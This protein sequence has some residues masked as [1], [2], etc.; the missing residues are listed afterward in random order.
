MLNL[1]KISTIYVKICL[2][3]KMATSKDYKNFIL[4]KLSKLN[5]CYKSMMGEFLLYVNGVYFGGIFDDRLLIKKTD[6]NSK[7]NLVR[8]KP[9][10]N[11]KPMGL[12]KMLMMKNILKNWF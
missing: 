3:E 8:A 4:E 1:T 9:Y 2:G 7:Y 6:T 10:E 12:V 11:A 5:P